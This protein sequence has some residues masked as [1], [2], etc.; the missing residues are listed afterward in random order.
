M[1]VREQLADRLH[2][3]VDDMPPCPA[4]CALDYGHRYESILNEDTDAGMVTLERC[5]TTQ[6]LAVDSFGSVGQEEHLR[7][8]RVSYGSVH[9][10][11]GRD[12]EEI[13]AEEARRRAAELVKLA[14]R[15][16]RAGGYD[17]IGSTT[18]PPR[19]HGRG[20]LSCRSVVTVGTCRPVAHD[21]AR[22]LPQ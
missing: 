13:T 21:A 6:R 18:A 5:H 7:D 8:G 9:I 12:L 10:V 19:P 4:W 14:D 16:E 15:L 17:V 1:Y 22:L 20:A 2:L 11:A 3:Q